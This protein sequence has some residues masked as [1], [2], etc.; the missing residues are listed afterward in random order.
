[1]VKVRQNFKKNRMA[2][3]LTGAKPL[4]VRRTNMAD[5][6]ER[7]FRLVFLLAFISIYSEH[8]LKI[9]FFIIWCHVRI[10]AAAYYIFVH[11]VTTEIYD[12]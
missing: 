3:V 4:Y 10:C 8:N 2:P 11:D 5:A 12:I 6:N 7:D 1:M 9:M